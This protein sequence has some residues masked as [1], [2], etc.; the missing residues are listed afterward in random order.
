MKT[1]SSTTGLIACA[2]IAGAFAVG[3]ATGP[4][5]AQEATSFETESFKF[6]FTYKASELTAAPSAEKLLVRLQQDVR[7]HCGGNRKM[8]LDER[9]RVNACINATMKESIGKF[10]S[11]TLAQAYETRA[12]G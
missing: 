11:S 2:V 8:T 10:G 6:Q 4:A 12:G 3:F 7:D 5:F 9:S 1:A